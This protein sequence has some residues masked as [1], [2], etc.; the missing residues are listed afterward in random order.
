MRNWPPDAGRFSGAGDR[1]VIAAARSA[2]YRRDPRSVADR[3]SHAA[4]ERHVSIRP[5]PDTMCYLTALLPVARRASPSYTALTRSAD[6][7]RSAGDPRSRGQLMAD[8]LVERTT[9][10][11]GGIGGIEIQL[12]MTDRTLFQGDSEPARLPGYGVVP[13]GWA[14]LSTCGN[15][16]FSEPG[17]RIMV[18]D[19]KLNGHNGLSSGSGGS[20]PPRT[21]AIW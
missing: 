18:A 14:I 13:A 4:A 6:A 11:P 21:P 5:A 3:A 12:I 16:R 2:A 8:A 10:T 15:E 1:A 19:A 17:Q 20:T 7:Q 9:G